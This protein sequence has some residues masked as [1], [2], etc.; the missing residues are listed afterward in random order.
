MDGE[1][2]QQQGNENGIKEEIVWMEKG[3]EWRTLGLCTGHSYV[4]VYINDLMNDIRP[5]SCSMGC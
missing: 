4:L 5:D 3:D 1:P 2:C